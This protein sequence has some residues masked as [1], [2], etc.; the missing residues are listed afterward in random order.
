MEDT[1]N[2]RHARGTGSLAH[3][4][5]ERRHLDAPHTYVDLT[6]ELWSRV[7]Q[8]N[9]LKSMHLFIKLNNR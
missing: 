2:K 1:R 5:P 4:L 3:Y 6:R 7:D 8:K 9:K